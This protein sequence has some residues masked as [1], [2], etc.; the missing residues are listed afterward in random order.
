MLLVGALLVAGPLLSAAGTGVA[1]RRGGYTGRFWSSTL[2]DK[3]DHVHGQRRFWWLLSIGQT[4]GLVVMTAGLAGLTSLLVTEGEPVLA[5]VAFGAYLTA[6][7]AWTAGLI[8]QTTTIPKAAEQR[9]A[10]GGTPEW[11]HGFWALGW[12]AE[13]TWVLGA[14]LAYAV[15]GWAILASGLV[16]AWAGWMAIVFGGGI[17]LVVITTRDGFPEMSQLVPLVLGVALILGGA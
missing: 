17:P 7:I 3:L 13:V 4:I 1:Y 2:D 8:A 11:M 14:N 6:L 12:M 5:F 15:M 9:A 16:G 10:T